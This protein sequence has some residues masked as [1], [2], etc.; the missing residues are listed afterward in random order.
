MLGRGISD[1]DLADLD[2]RI[3]GDPVSR[4]EAKM[5][6]VARLPGETARAHRCFLLWAMMRRDRRIRAQFCRLFDFTVRWMHKWSEANAWD[7]RELNPESPS[8]AAIEYWRLYGQSFG[9]SEVSEIAELLVYEYPPPSELLIGVEQVANGAFEEDDQR[10]AEKPEPI[11]EPTPPAPPE[12]PGATPA[13][14][15][16]VE[17]LRAASEE[18]AEARKNPGGVGEKAKLKA[19]ANNLMAG[20][21]QALTAKG[22]CKRCGE[23]PAPDPRCLTCSGRGW[24][25]TYPFHLLKPV[26]AVHLAR[27]VALV[28]E[29]AAAAL[30]PTTSIA[31]HNT[32]VDSVRVRHARANGGDVLGAQIED[33]EEARVVLEQ[34]RISGAG[35]RVSGRSG[36]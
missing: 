31:T 18:L 23:K 7:V 6:L 4:R 15:P 33:L 1:Q 16:T 26:D 8:Y 9:D 2:P 19:I 22:P 34:L 5:N 21:G 30:L 27:L 13:K 10:L 20:F 36:G 14:A 17:E 24:V 11:Q 35:A 29:E 12:T 28:D 32:V 3:R 25:Y